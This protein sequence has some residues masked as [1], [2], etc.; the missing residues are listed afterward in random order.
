LA[1]N[2]TKAGRTINRRVEVRYTI[3]EEKRVRVQ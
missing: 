3:R 2:K 1:D